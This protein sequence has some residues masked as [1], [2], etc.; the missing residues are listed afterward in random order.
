MTNFLLH[1]DEAEED[2]S[3]EVWFFCLVTEKTLD[4]DFMNHH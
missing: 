4:A 3:E 1:Q 2:D